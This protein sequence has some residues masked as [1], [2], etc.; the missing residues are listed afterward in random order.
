MY[1]SNVSFVKLWEWLS[2]PGVSSDGS[3]WSVPKRVGPQRCLSSADSLA[4]RGLLTLD[5]ISSE[6]VQ[7]LRVQRE[8]SEARFGKDRGRKAG[9]WTPWATNAGPWP[10]SECSCTFGFNFQFV[11]P[12]DSVHHFQFWS[13]FQHACYQ[14]IPRHVLVCLAL[15][16]CLETAIQ[17]LSKWHEPINCLSGIHIL[18]YLR[19][20]QILSD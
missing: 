7:A 1:R 12:P 18:Y 13:P 11:R 9:V 4:P 20:F 8:N 16:S 10:V 5:S 3:L 17:N 2:T 15:I 6:A 19:S 14:S